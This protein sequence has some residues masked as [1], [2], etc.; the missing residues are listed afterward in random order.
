MQGLHKVV[1]PGK[2]SVDGVAEGNV[3]TGGGETRKGLC[4]TLCQVP[5]PL[6]GPLTKV[7]TTPFLIPL[8]FNAIRGV[9]FLHALFSLSALLSQ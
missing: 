6:P 1:Q 8:Q 3:I 9:L 4:F 7:K 5:Q 2:L